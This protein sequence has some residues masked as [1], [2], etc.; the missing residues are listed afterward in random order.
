MA[1]WGRITRAD[2][3]GF[4]DLNISLAL[5]AG[6]FGWTGRVSS[7]GHLIMRSPDGRAT[8]SLARL[9]GKRAHRNNLADFR[10]WLR[11]QDGR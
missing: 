6:R 5:E 3:R 7:K 10:R 9:E 4:G 1:R 2:L 11:S 8:M